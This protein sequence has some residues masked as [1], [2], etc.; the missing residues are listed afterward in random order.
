M[1]ENIF[2]YN[3]Y[4]IETVVSEVL[5]VKVQVFISTPEICFVG[6][7]VRQLIWSKKCRL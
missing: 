7:R 2:F 5:I 4:D 3:F 6:V 1:M